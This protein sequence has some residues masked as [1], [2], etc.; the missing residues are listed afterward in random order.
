MF[1]RPGR[2]QGLLYKQEA[3]VLLDRASRL[4]RQDIIFSLDKAGTSRDKAEFSRDTRGTARDKAGTLRDE[5]GT[6][7]DQAGTTRNQ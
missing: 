2:S 5:A 3:E 1:S 7:R 4:Y 6:A